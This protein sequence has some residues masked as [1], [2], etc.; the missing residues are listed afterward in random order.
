M[1][2][3]KVFLLNEN[4]SIFVDSKKESNTQFGIFK[5]S[6]IANKKPGSRVKTHNGNVFYVVEPGTPDLIKK[7]IRLPQ[8]VT[9]KD[10][11]SIVMYLGVKSDSK[12]FDAG[13][14]SG[15]IACSIANLSKEIKVFSYEVRKEFMKVAKKNAELFALD[16]IKFTNQD[17]KQG[18]KE[19]NFD[20]GVLDLP[21]PW[22]VLPVI[23]KNFKVGA[24]IV[25]Y[26]PSI[27]QVE[28]TIRSLPKNLKVERL[29]QNNEINWKVE[30]ERDILR[31]ESNG[32]LHTGFLLFVRKVTV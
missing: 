6:K 12:V 18:I 4:H 20:C 16:N 31:P 2:K 22:E 5:P 14:G 29:V 19:K 9:L 15:V 23:T 13:T 24:R 7:I 10:V 21:D 30:I 1:K 8:I 27:I 32:I 11:G 28:K 3:D 25:T 26:S 17:V